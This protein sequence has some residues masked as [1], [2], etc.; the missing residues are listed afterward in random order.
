M[1]E[2]ERGKRNR[3]R[4]EGLGRRR[5][6]LEKSKKERGTMEQEEIAGKSEIRS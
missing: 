1:R 5:T 2:K 4:E 6:T 3:R